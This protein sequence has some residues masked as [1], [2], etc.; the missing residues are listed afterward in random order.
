VNLDECISSVRILLDEPEMQRPSPHVIHLHLVSNYQLIFNVAMNASPNWEVRSYDLIVGSGTDKFL[1]SA[2]DFGKPVL[3]HT[4]NA[5]NPQFVERP[6]S[7]CD[8]QELPNMWR[9]PRQVALIDNPA[10]PSAEVMAFYWQDGNPWV[11]VRPEPTGS[12]TYRVWYETRTVKPELSSQP[13]LPVGNAYLNYSTAIGCLPH[14]HWHGF[15]FEQDSAHR[16]ELA[17]SLGMRE[18]GH[19]D[20]FKKYLATGKQDGPIRKRPYAPDR[21]SGGFQGGG[22][23]Y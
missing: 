17:Q 20:A 23:T 7:I 21:F 6:I 10:N 16:G 19:H 3:V 14:C 22:P 18:A 2:Q 13:I 5:S 1:I 11:L 15:T 9:G 4:Y 12:A 8:I